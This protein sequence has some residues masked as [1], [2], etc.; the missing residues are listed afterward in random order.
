VF[1]RR[2]SGEATIDPAAVCVD[3]KDLLDLI[4]IGRCAEESVQFVMNSEM[5]LESFF[6]PP[7]PLQS[8]LKR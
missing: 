1:A 6:K 2:R 3:E 8:G 4:V 5:D 7:F